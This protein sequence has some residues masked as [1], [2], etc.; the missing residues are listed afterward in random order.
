MQIRMFPNDPRVRFEKKIH[1]QVSPALARAGYTFMY[2]NDTEIVHTGYAHE[3]LKH[4]KALRNRTILEDD[5][6]NYPGDINYVAAYADTFFITNEWERGIEVYKEV[7]AIPGAREKQ[8]D[9][10]NRCP[11]L[12][13]LGY[14]Q[15]KR[16]PS[17]LQWVENGLSICPGRADLFLIGGEVSFEMRE[18]AKARGMLDQAL[19]APEELSSVPI[20]YQAIRAKAAIMQA[21]ICREEKDFAGAEKWYQKVMETHSY[22]FDMPANIGEVVLAQGRFLDAMRFF[23]DS[24]I[25]FP[26]ADVRAY[27]HLGRISASV[28]KIDEAI[29]MY[30]KGLSFFPADRAMLEA[31]RDLYRMRDDTEKY[32]EIS[33][34]LSELNQTV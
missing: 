11:V 1:E 22:F 26:G 23:S 7:M 17:A 15:L 13:A 30:S 16:F 14:Q 6:K 24:V 34:R 10:Y 32:L 28:G 2:L 5:M 29:D 4:E 9:L 31:I 33:Q 18:F 25:R 8:P 19:A 20:D 21:R 3:G 27:R 12:I